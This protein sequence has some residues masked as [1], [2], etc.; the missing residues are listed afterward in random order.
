MKRSYLRRKRVLLPLLSLVGLLASVVVAILRSET[1]RIIVYNQTGETIAAIKLDACG[2]SAVFR[3]VEDDGSVRWKLEKSEAAGEVE[4]ETG[5]TP[6]IHWK[7]ASVHAR[8]GYMVTLRVWSD[9][10]VED[11]TQI[12][13]WYRLVHGM[14]DVN[15]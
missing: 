6:E 1:S 3:N 12:T 9:G 4:L 14:P 5:P 8:G 7:G 10:T 2:Q 13:L 11:H 15:E